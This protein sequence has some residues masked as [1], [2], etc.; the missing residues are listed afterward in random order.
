MKR[1][2]QRLVL[3]CSLIFLTGCQPLVFTIGGP[4]PA[5]Q[6]TETTV[7]KAKSWTSNRV[8]IID[9]SG[10]I[11]N[12]QEASLFGAGDHPVSKLH[13][14]LERA[15]EDHRVKAIILRIDSP[16]G[17]VTASDMM[18]REVL[19][20]KKESKKPVIVM[21]MGVAASGGYYLACAG[22]EILAYPTTVT[23]SIGVIM[24]TLNVNDALSN[25]GIKTD[26]IKSGKNKD[27]GSPFSKSSDAQRQTLQKIVDTFYG[28]FTAL[29][30]ESRKGKIKPHNFKMVTDGRVF[31][32]DDALALG[33]VD[34]L[35]DI[36]TAFNTAKKHANINDAYLVV[37]HRGNGYIGSVY[38]KSNATTPTNTLNSG[39]Q[40]NIQNLGLSNQSGGSFYY[41]WQTGK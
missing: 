4:G 18:Y 3:A 21:M 30:K 9:I 14:S 16:G 20:F 32:G 24:Q 34:Q 40:I 35:G 25:W 7:V 38:S 10:M 2:I 15:A 26:A 41:L 1:N 29:V 36:Y 19:R 6:I 5:P 23:G 33:L 13:E 31:S 39:T 12:S 22:D 37:Y 28:R 8:A 27:A 17:T 11:M